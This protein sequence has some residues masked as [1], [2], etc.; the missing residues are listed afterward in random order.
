MIQ[1]PIYMISDALYIAHEMLICLHLAENICHIRKTCQKAL[2][3]PQMVHD[4]RK[5]ATRCICQNMISSFW[6]LSSMIVPKLFN[7]KSILTEVY[8]SPGL[9]LNWLGSITACQFYSRAA[10][11]CIYVSWPSLSRRSFLLKIT[12][13]KKLF[14]DSKSKDSTSNKSIW[15]L[16]K[17]QSKK[18]VGSIL[19]FCMFLYCY[20]TS[21]HRKMF[22]LLMENGN[23]NHSL[24]R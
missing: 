5:H 22:V 1:L 16:A 13:G 14:A 7:K 9:S 23:R 17:E 21:N 19:L 12:A 24:E 18:L 4:N 3:L 2:A 11:C 20:G 6:E 10:G 15:I 8:M